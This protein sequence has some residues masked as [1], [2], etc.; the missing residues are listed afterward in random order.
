[1]PFILATVGSINSRTAVQ[2][3]LGKKGDPISKITRAKRARGAAQVVECLP[4]KWKALSLNPSTDQ[5]RKRGMQ[6]QC[7]LGRQ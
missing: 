5:E 6:K 7:V 1:M 3:S 2:A 4:S